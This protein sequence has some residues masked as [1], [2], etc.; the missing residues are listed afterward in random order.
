MSVA[1]KYIDEEEMNAMKDGEWRIGSDRGRDSRRDNKGM[2]RTDRN[3]RRDQSKEPTYQQRYKNYT[4]LNMMRAKV[5]MMVEKND[6]LKWPKHTRFTPAKKYSNKYCIFHREKGHDT[7]ECYQLKDEIERLVRQG[8]FKNQV[9]ENSRDRNN[10]SRSRSQERRQD[11]EFNTRDPRIREN[12][13]VKDIIHTI[14][15]GTEDAGDKA[16]SGNDP[17]VIKLDIAN[18]VVHKVLVDNGSS[19]DIILKKVLVKMRLDNVKLAPVKT[20]LVG[21]RGS[22]VDSLGTIDLPV[23]MGE[24]PRRKTLMVTFLVVDTHF[25]YNVI[26]GRPGINSFRAIVSTFHLKMKFPTPF[27]VGEV[28]CDQREAKRCYNLSLKKGETNKRRRVEK[29]DDQWKNK[30]VEKEVERIEPIEKHK[31][32]ELVRGEHSKTTR[33]GSG[34]ARDLETHMIAFLRSNVDIFAWDP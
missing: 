13:P 33:I 19:A 10:R 31:E 28:S 16:G 15:G 25:A 23:S 8:Y 12:A 11:K 4:P 30:M 7:E 20:P 32:I 3:P 6:V 9:A 26:L 29:S 34:M 17:M 27:G 21:F 22:E 2:D 1:Q 14:A 5:L 18:F 24:E